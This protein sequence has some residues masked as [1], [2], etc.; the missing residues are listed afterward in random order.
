MKRLLIICLALV[1]GFAPAY[2]GFNILT[3]EGAKAWIEASFQNPQYGD[4]VDIYNRRDVHHYILLDNDAAIDG[5]EVAGYGHRFDIHA[6]I[7]EDMGYGYSRG[8]FNVDLML[9]VKD[10]KTH[11][12]IDFLQ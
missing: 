7:A 5:G 3:K 10:G 2:G 11:M 4:S 12:T 9:F 8:P 6:V 1:S